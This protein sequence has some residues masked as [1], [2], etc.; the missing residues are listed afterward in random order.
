MRTQNY[1]SIKAKLKSARKAKVFYR[2][3]EF[4][5]GALIA[6]LVI[7]A[8]FSR[9]IYLEAPDNQASWTTFLGTIYV[10]EYW[11]NV[12]S[13]LYA[14]ISKL[15]FIFFVSLC[16][17]SVN[18][19]WKFSLLVPIAMALYQLAAII[20]DNTEVIDEFEW[21]SSLPITLPVIIA[22]TAVG[23]FTYNKKTTLNINDAIENE[24]ETYLNETE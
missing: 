2:N 4:Y 14:I 5:K 17:F 15:Y 1:K 13:Y 3:V 12:Q 22:L 16:Y 18:K 10:N 7:S 6:I 23:I 9:H 11:D 20:N 8:P 21:Y 24:Y 19:L